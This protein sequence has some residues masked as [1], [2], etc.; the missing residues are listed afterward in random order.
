MNTNYKAYS[1]NLVNQICI[2]KTEAKTTVTVVTTADN[3]QVPRDYH[4][5]DKNLH[6]DM[7]VQANNPG[8]IP[9]DIHEI[10]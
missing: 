4:I 9:G 2:F 6:K 10:G 8:R 5:S 3:L 1:S 7:R